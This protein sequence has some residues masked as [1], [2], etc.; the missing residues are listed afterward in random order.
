MRYA[1][2]QI[3]KMYMFGAAGPNNFDCSGLTQMAWKQAGVN[4]PHNAAQQ[5]QRTAQGQ[6]APTAAR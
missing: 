3:G 5:Y 6:R 1:Y 4:L 2:A